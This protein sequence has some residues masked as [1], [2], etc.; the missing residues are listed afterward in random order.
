MYVVKTQ[1]LAGLS[2]DD[3]D[4]VDDEDICCIQASYT[5]WLIPVAVVMGCMVIADIVLT[6]LRSRR[7]RMQAFEVKGGTESTRDEKPDHTIEAD[8]VVIDTAIYPGNGNS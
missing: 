4:D 5:Q 6:L 1:T 2:D 7:E 3:D 8:G